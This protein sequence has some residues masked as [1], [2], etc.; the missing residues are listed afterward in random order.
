MNNNFCPFL[1]KQPLVSIISYKNS[2]IAENLPMRHIDGICRRRWI[3]LTIISTPVW[4]FYTSELQGRGM[5]SRQRLKK[6]SCKKL[7]TTIEINVGSFYLCLISFQNAIFKIL[8]N[9][10]SLLK[11]IVSLQYLQD[12]SDDRDHLSSKG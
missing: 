2:E 11:S 9:L 5:N 6:N 1:K 4:T 8:D 3:L 10:L 12:Y 7:L